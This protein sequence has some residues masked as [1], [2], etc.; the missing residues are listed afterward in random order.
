VPNSVGTNALGTEFNGTFGS[1]C[2]RTVGTSANVPTGYAYAT[3][4]SGT[5]QD[6]YYGLANNTS[7]GANFS[8]SNAWPKP[9]NSCLR[10][11]CLMYGTLSATIPAPPIRTPAN[12]PGNNTNASGYMW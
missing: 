2:R 4:T 8:T 9:D 1:V 11:G 3:F 5:P 6:Y 7:N 10:T 12:A